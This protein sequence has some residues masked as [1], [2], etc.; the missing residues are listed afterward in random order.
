MGGLLLEAAQRLVNSEAISKT[1]S[2]SASQIEIHRFLR[3]IILAT[4]DLVKVEAALLRAMRRLLAKEAQSGDPLSKRAGR[5]TTMTMSLVQGPEAAPGGEEEAIL[6]FLELARHLHKA[7][8]P[9]AQSIRLL[10]KSG[11]LREIGVDS[12]RERRAPC[13]RGRR[14]EM[15]NEAIRILHATLGPEHSWTVRASTRDGGS[16]PRSMSSSQ[17]S[18]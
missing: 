6:L 11:R 12:F 18:L 8:G 15:V 3:K 17:P 2:D 16:T 9:P 4:S 13:R 10:E 1:D 7:G 5:S 14:G